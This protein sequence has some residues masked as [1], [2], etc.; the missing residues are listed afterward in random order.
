MQNVR[1]IRSLIRAA[2]RAAAAAADYFPKCC[3]PVLCV[4]LSKES[5]KVS[6]FLVLR[7]TVIDGESLCSR[8]LFPVLQSFF[9]SRM[10]PGI[11]IIAIF[12]SKSPSSFRLSSLQTPFDMK[13]LA[14]SVFPCGLSITLSA[15]QS[16]GEEDADLLF[17]RPV[18][19][20]A[21]A[22]APPLPFLYLTP[23]D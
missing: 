15:V 18:C 11:I 3:C 10:Q 22:A 23:R 19:F 21:A 8:F 6:P 16:P 17:L 14:E 4:L 2:M 12:L 7:Q 13:S 5:R 1:R 9:Y 20:G